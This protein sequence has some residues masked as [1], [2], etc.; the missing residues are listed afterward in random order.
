VTLLA[1]SVDSLEDTAAMANKAGLKLTLLADVDRRVIKAYG[2]HD[3]GNDIAWPA[4]F[5]VDREGAVRW[6]LLTQTYKQ[7]PA[8]AVVL[9]A[10]DKIVR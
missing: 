10:V 4:I 2:V 3:K 9:E 5:I 7:R 1:I 8:A 6:R